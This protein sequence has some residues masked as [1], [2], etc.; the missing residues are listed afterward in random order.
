MCFKKKETDYRSL[1][2]EV[3]RST[4]EKYNEFK[5]YISENP[6]YDFLIGT[7]WFNDIDDYCYYPL[8]E[9]NYEL[10]GYVDEATYENVKDKCRKISDRIRDEKVSITDVINTMKENDEK[11]TAF[12]QNTFARFFV[13]EPL[14]GGQKKY[15]F[16]CHKEMFP[17]TLKMTDNGF[18]YLDICL[19]TTEE[20]TC[21]VEQI[22]STDYI[23]R[24]M[25]EWEFRDI[26]LPLRCEKS[27][28]TNENELVEYSNELNKLFIE[29]S[30]KLKK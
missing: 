13:L 4:V 2:G 30:I 10:F 20:S 14:F 25:Y 27:D 22:F 7:E 3:K 9:L 29:D 5:K 21:Q 24:P 19:M 18:H 15:C 26:Y 1:A 23:I 28:I 12:C 11:F 6:K 8:S 16:S 17:E